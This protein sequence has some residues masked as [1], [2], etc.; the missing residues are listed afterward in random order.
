M[1]PFRR[2]YPRSITL[3]LCIV[4]CCAAVAQQIPISQRMANATITRWPQGRFT[5]P[6]EKWKWNYELATLLNGMNAVWY[7]TADGSYF[8]YI[9]E[10]VDTLVSP[11]GSIPTYD[12]AASTLDN[13]A[14]GREL[15]LLYRVTR[16]ARYYK[17]ATLLRGQLSTQPRAASG[18]FWHKQIYPEQMWL[19]GLYMAEPFYAEYAEVFQEPQDFADITQQFTLMEAH[20]RDPK[21][22]LLYHAWDES[23]KQPWSNKTTGASR[24]FWARGMGWYMMALADALPFYPQNDPGRA[25][26]IGILNRTAQAVALVQDAHTGLWY[27]VLDKP[28]EKG[29]YFESSAA[30]MFAYALEKGV[31]LGYLPAQYSANASRAWKGIQDH[32]VQTGTDGSITLTSSVKA[33]GLGGTP[34]RDGSYD[35]YVHAPVGDNDPKGVGAFLLAASEME[36][37]PDRPKAQFDARGQTVVV[38]AWF[39][40]QKRKNAAG[41][42]EFFH[43]KWDDMSDSGYSLLGSMFASHGAALGTLYSAPTAK[44]LEQAQYYV[45]ASPDNPSKN[46]NPHYAQPE[47]GEEIAKWVKQGGVLVLLENDPPNADIEHFNNIADRFGI[48]FNTVL[49]HHVVGDD[50]APGLIAVQPDGALF[51]GAHTLYMKDTCTITVSAAARSLLTDRGTI[52]I[53]TTKY[54]KGTVFA[55]VDPWIYNEYTDGRKRAPIDD[56]FAAGQEVVRWLIEQQKQQ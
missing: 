30:C 12:P 38:D 26:L 7:S 14:L 43:Y 24:I 37:S 32:F 18:G 1:L 15:L 5:V 13:I 52:V 36:N 31:R 8:R 35:Y 21:T 23:R 11:D 3:L 45:I 39:N 29:N 34:Y 22:G 47:D 17:A 9:K 46:P 27:Q 44:N 54:G 56:N 20:A 6:D 41:Q 2:F 16:D 28:G 51:H 53:A 4:F 55:V 48:H 42:D 10:S 19:D 49:S 25:R 40:S 33:V 50:Y